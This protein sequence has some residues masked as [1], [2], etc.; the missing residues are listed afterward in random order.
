MDKIKRFTQSIGMLLT[1]LF[2]FVIAVVLA[3]LMQLS[4]LLGYI[5]NLFYENSTVYIIS[6][7]VSRLVYFWGSML[8]GLFLSHLLEKMDYLKLDALPSSKYEATD[9]SLSILSILIQSGVGIVFSELGIR[10]ITQ[11]T[12]PKF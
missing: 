9:K 11:T 10:L 4:G 6:F 12:A 5:D 8:L 1:V 2:V 7:V 3:K